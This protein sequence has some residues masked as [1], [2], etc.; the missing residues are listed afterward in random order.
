MSNGLIQI[1]KKSN[2]ALIKKFNQTLTM[3]KFPS[4]L[5]KLKADAAELS[6]HLIAV[7]VQVKF[8]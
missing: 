5:M 2:E 3:T 4:V 1:E 8:K 6:V 7:F